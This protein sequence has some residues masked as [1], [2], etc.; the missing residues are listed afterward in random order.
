MGDV[1]LKNKEV[2]TKSLGKQRVKNKEK[3]HWF[4]DRG[5]GRWDFRFFSFG[6]FEGRFFGFCIE[7]LRFLGL[8]VRCGFLFF[9]FYHLVFRFFGKN[10]AVFRILVT[11]VVFGFSTDLE[12]NQRQTCTGFQCGF[13]GCVTLS[14]AFKFIFALKSMPFKD[15]PLL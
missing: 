11:D 13:C 3:L 5:G 7:K 2:G 9:L 6:H 8:V 14:T 12:G 10:K 1:K 15:L 4:L